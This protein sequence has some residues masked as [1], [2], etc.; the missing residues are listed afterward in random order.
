MDEWPNSF[1]RRGPFHAQESF[2][3]A[4]GGRRFKGL[5]F[6]ITIAER[7]GVTIIPDEEGEVKFVKCDRF[8]RGWGTLLPF[9]RRY[10]SD[11]EDLSAFVGGE[12][13]GVIPQF[14]PSAV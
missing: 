7:Y 11:L 1:L 5:D 9:L 13:C 3:G 10:S 14:S 4:I 12:S 2:L 6:L 8:H